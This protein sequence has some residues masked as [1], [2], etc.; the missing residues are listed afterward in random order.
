MISLH[1]QRK[2]FTITV[3]LAYATTTNVEE[4]EVEWFNEDLED[5]LEL[6]LKKKKGPFHHWRVK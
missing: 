2:P 1:F 6:T 3:I 5:F 4:A